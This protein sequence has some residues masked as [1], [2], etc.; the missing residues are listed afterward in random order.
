MSRHVPLLALSLGYFMVIVDA[1]IV[2]VALP[3][4]RADLSTT[5]SALQW[6]VDAYV[7]VFAALLLSGGALADRVG[8][9]RALRGGLLLFVAASVAC[10]LAP[11]VTALIAARAVQGVGAALLVPA[12][13]ALLRASYADPS[14]RARAIGIWGAVAGIGAASG[15]ILGGLLVT[16]ASWR[17]VFFVNLPVGL[18]AI[19]LLERGVRR[20]AGNP[21]RALDVPGQ[22]LA[23]ASLAGLT[24]GLIE[25]GPRGVADPLVLGGLGAFAIGGAAFLAVERRSRDPMLPLGLFSDAGFAGANAV[26]LLINLGFYGQLFVIN[27][28]FQQVRGASAL[29][30]GLALLP[31]AGLLTVASIAAGRLAARSG[32]RRPMLLGLLLGAAGLLGLMVAGE[33]T[34]YVVLVPPLIAAGFGMAL[35]MP[36]ATTAVIQAAPGDRAGLAS[37]VINASRQTGG[38]TGVALL[39]TLVAGPAAFVS[40]MHLAMATAGG[41]FLLGAGVA[42]LTVD[43]RPSLR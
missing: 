6:V 15:P 22:L 42:A 36:S 19:A 3:D 37:G 16:A 27:L 11:G 17:A 28:Y 43:P 18:A 33:E 31:E 12:S 20:V 38:V 24:L 7:L 2:N 25:I 4:L 34:A 10:G 14:E 40:G 35:T 32:P 9:G 21:A 13:L 1:T 29:G 41:T 30:A 26:G 39:G 8:A 5:V 23:V